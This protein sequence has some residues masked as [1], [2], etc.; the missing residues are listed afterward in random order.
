MKALVFHGPGQIVYESFDDPIISQEENLIV[1][2]EK[3]SIC[4][5]DLHHYHGDKIGKTDYSKDMEAFCTGHEVIGEVM[6][7]GRSVKSHRPGDRIVIAAG[8][9]CGKC[10]A[11]R[12]GK[13][14][15]C[16]A[17]SR[18]E[19]PMAY[20]MNAQLHGGHADYRLSICRAAT[21]E[22]FCHHALCAPSMGS[23]IAR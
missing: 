19:W 22:R 18:G 5:S 10:K 23:T 7:V 15:L 13:I 3:C 16:E 1:K 21:K 17:S 6:E 8:K 20:G 2:V 11:C 4:G 12:T 9:G 14:N